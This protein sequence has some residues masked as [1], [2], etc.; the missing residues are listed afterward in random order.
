MSIRCPDAVQH[1]QAAARNCGEELQFAATKVQRG[2]DV[3]GRHYSGSERQPGILSLPY[4]VSVK[5]WRNGKLRTS[6]NDF[7]NLVCVQNRADSRK[8]LRNVFPNLTQPFDGRI[9]SQSQFHSID[10]TGQ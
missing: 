5:S 8:H 7:I 10:A 4:H 6:T 2:F 1:R 3:C 9:S